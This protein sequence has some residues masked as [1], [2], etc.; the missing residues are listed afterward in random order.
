MLHLTACAILWDFVRTAVLKHFEVFFLHLQLIYPRKTTSS[1]NFK[2]SLH[3]V[4]I[5]VGNSKVKTGHNRFQSDS[6]L[7]LDTVRAMQLQKHI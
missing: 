1:D 3:I 4:E 7:S 6:S 2:W 5:K